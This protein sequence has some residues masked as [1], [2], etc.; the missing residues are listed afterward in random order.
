MLSLP[1]CPD[2]YGFLAQILSDIYLYILQKTNGFVRIFLELSQKLCPNLVQISE[3]KLEN[4][5]S[6]QSEEWE[7]KIINEKLVSRSWIWPGFDLDF[8]SKSARIFV[9]ISMGN[10][11]RIHTEK[12]LTDLVYV[13]RSLCMYMFIKIKNIAF[14]LN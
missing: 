2:N 5:K 9:R 14:E 13:Y 12:N 3:M 10:A 6:H 7:K 8:W 4:K 11:R 1:D